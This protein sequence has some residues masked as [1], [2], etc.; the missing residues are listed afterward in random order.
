MTSAGPVER[1]PREQVLDVLLEAGTALDAADV[2]G[3][4][5]VH[6]TTARFHLDHLARAG[7][8][9]RR[10]DS[11]GRRGRPRMLFSPAAGT[12]G[13]RSREQLIAVLVAA[14]ARDAD[15]PAES[16]RAGRRWADALSA[17]MPEAGTDAGARLVEELDA[18]GFAPERVPDGIRLSA[19]PFREAAQAHPEV[20]CAVH[21]GL[22]ERLVAAA[23]PHRPVQL[24]P[25]VEPDVCLIRLDR[26]PREATA[27]HP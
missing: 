1:T 26:E 14:L 23:E 17:R 15:A 9:Q 22:V 10:P 5:G 7:L 3:R 21:R 2:A 8:A 16:L 4:L 13:D 25:F 20:V 27:A 6:V 24:L 18:L 11:T 12:R 19:C